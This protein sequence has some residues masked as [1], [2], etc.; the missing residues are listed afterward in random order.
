LTDK[1][2]E[3]E[4]HFTQPP[5]RYTEASLVKRLE[6]LGIGRPSTFASTLA[7]LVERE[8]VRNDKKK[9]IPED[10]G[11]LVTA[12]L[13]NYFR[14]YVEY[15]YTAGLEE[16]LDLIS[17]NKLDWKAMLREFWLEFSGA[18]GE[19]KELRVTEVLETLNEVLGPAIFPA[20]PD[21]SDARACASCGTGRL[22]LKP[23]K[24]GPF[25][26]CSNYPEC[27]YTRQFSTSGDG[28]AEANTP[29]G[30]I[31]G[32]DPDTGLQV[33]LKTG[34]FG[35]YLQLGEA[36]GK[37]DKPKRS[38]IPKGIDAATIDLER[39]LQ[40]LN[41]PR[42]V[43]VHPETGK[44]I[45]AGLGRFGPFLLHDG[46]YA[47]LASMEE[48]F[49]VG[50]NR[51]VAVIA[52]KAA[53]KG[54]GRFQRGAPKA[55]REIGEH[56]DGGKIE[57]FEGKYGPY[58]KHGATNATIPK[59]KDPAALTL[60]EAVDIIAARIEKGG[61]KPPKKKAAPKKAAGAAA[62][63]GAKAAAKG[64]AKGVAKSKSKKPVEA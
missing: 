32:N 42:A 16:K 3:A 10:K 27:R 36:A 26:G 18:V 8:Y 34:R 57:V 14:R 64:G 45:T 62:K 49:T 46:K 50:I 1:A 59:G 61:G 41:L 5:P 21:G 7:T 44:E 20:K 38:S 60:L 43:G 23:G 58:V 4:Q 51:A 2:I 15:D 54:G 30:K 53:G 19:T 52:D 47:N 63:P 6:E 13:A 25:I 40:L 29:E 31:I 48:V 22:S 37:D 33:A 24:F 35:P 11:R 56:P 12:F 9:L 17:D 39:A 28:P 55:L